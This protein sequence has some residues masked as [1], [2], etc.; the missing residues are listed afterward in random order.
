MP[1]RL[2]P[3]AL[4]TL[5]DSKLATF[6]TGQQKKTRF[7]REKEAK[8]AKKQKEL[9]EAAQIYGDFVASFDGSSDRDSKSFVR[10]GG[11]GHYGSG[12]GYQMNSSSSRGGARGHRA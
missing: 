1:P 2:Q 4:K 7:Q 8:E 12:D 6:V 3:G 10:S 11:A 5:S 9:E